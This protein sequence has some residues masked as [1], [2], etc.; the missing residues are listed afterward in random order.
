MAC[1]GGLAEVGELG[2]GDSGDSY[3]AEGGNITILLLL[4]SHYCPTLLACKAYRGGKEQ[5]RFT[6]SFRFYFCKN[7]DHSDNAWMAA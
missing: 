5:H 7:P 3:F 4:I 2:R 1:G 6:L